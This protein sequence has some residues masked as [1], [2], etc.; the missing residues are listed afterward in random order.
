MGFRDC[1]R[2]LPVLVPGRV[3][4]PWPEP[5]GNRRRDAPRPCHSQEPASAP[6]PRT[7]PRRRWQASQRCS[8]DR[9]ACGGRCLRCRRTDRV[10]A[11]SLGRR[12]LPFCSGAGPD[13]PVP[14][15]GLAALNAALLDEVPRVRARAAC[16]LVALRGKDAA[17]TVPVLIAALDDPRDEVR[18]DAAASLGKL[19]LELDRVVPA[20][21]RLLKDPSR[22]VRTIVAV[23]LAELGPAATATVPALLEAHND[24]S[25]WVRLLVA[26]ALQRIDRTPVPAKLDGATGLH[27]AKVE[28]LAAAS[29]TPAKLDGATG[30]QGPMPQTVELPPEVAVLENPEAMV[31]F[32]PRRPWGE[33]GRLLGS[34]AFAACG[35]LVAA[36]ISSAPCCERR[37][38]CRCSAAVAGLVPRIAPGTVPSGHDPLP[39]PVVRV[40]IEL[41]RA[42]RPVAAGSESGVVL[43]AEANAPRSLALGP[44]VPA[45]SP[46]AQRRSPPR[47]L[48]VDLDVSRLAAR[49]RA[50]PRPGRARWNAT[51]N[52]TSGSLTPI[53]AAG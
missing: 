43:L 9:P 49:V 26:I 34:A 14:C 35:L 45:R 42:G 5:V 28:E 48:S 41:V 44:M 39:R 50:V 1:A 12:S 2:R 46:A 16:A 40:P 3:R 10:L 18:R 47:N 8:T 27:R 51:G 24:R 33:R 19:G 13:G 31:L 7:A 25:R 6:H 30:L 53:R 23:A 4:R 17:D 32:L 37:L 52:Q 22:E 21:A 20:L 29:G 38:V 36:C 11:R 15:T